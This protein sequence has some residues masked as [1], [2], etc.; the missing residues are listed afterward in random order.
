MVIQINI[1]K[2]SRQTVVL[3]N[4]MMALTSVKLVLM[5]ML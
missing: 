4:I 5:I 2:L 1:V 3:E